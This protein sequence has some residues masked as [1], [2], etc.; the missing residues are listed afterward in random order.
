MPGSCFFSTWNFELDPCHFFMGVI[1]DL[2]QGEKR[3]TVLNLGTGYAG[4]PGLAGKLS[5]SLGDL[6]FLKQLTIAPGMVAGGIPKSLGKLSELRFVG[7]SRNRLSGRIPESLAG[8]INLEI[9]D[10][11]KNKLTGSIPKGLGKIPNLVAVTLSDNNLYGPMPS[12][13]GRIAHLDLARNNLRGSL[14]PLSHT[15]QFLSLQR[16]NLAGG[17]GSLIPLQSLAYIDLCFNQFTGRV[18]QEVF[19]LKL[20]GLYLQHNKLS[21]SIAP[22]GPVQI[23]TIDLSYN[24]LSGKL[25]PFLATAQILYLNNNRFSGTVPLAYLDSLLSTYLEI[26][27]L[28][29]NYLTDFEV[30]SDVSLPTSGSLCIQYNCMVP[31]TQSTC[32]LKSGKQVSR[33]RYQCIHS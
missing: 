7:I 33:P 13:S 22:T 1:C 5:S 26:L 31:P 8:L 18:P 24:S 14:P 12:F 15:L 28:Q 19:D 25:P 4:V 30:H 27:Y 20:S 9:L 21:G 10:L 23:K 11:S 32:P 3:V 16:N 17:L 2:I 6:A 29:H